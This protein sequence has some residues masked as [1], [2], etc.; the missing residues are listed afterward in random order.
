MTGPR[1]AWP[2]DWASPL[3]RRPRGIALLGAVG[4]PVTGLGAAPAAI[5]DAMGRDKKARDGRV[6]FVLAP[7]IGSFRI[8]FDVPRDAIRETLDTLATT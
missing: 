4:L 3:P 8:V 6:P 5:I 1:P 2:S 7:E